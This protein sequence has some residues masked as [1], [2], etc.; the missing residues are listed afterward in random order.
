M[1][2]VIN[3]DEAKLIK[4]YEK[5]KHILINQE[6]I[7]LLNHVDKLKHLEILHLY[8]PT[9]LQIFAKNKN[10]HSLTLCNPNQNTIDTIRDLKGIQLLQ[11]Y[12]TNDNLEQRLDFSSC[13]DILNIENLGITSSSFIAPKEELRKKIKLSN[14]DK[15]LN[16]NLND[17]R[18]E[19]RFVEGLD[20]NDLTPNLEYISLEDY[21]DADVLLNDNIVQVNVDTKP[22]QSLKTYFNFNILKNLENLRYLNLSIQLL[23][24]NIN[25]HILKTCKNIELLHLNDYYRNQ[26]ISEN[27]YDL[28]FLKYLPNLI[29]IQYPNLS[30]QIILESKKYLIKNKIE[31]LAFDWVI[32][33]NF[34]IQNEFKN[35]YKISFDNPDPWILFENDELKKIIEDDIEINTDNFHFFFDTNLLKLSDNYKRDFPIIIQLNEFDTKKDTK[36]TLNACYYPDDYDEG[37]FVEDLSF[38]KNFQNLKELYI[39]DGEDVDNEFDLSALGFLKNLETVMIQMHNIKNIEVIFDLP[40][41]Y[42]LNLFNYNFENIANSKSNVKK[43]TTNGN[44]EKIIKY[45]ELFPLLEEIEIT[46][47]DSIEDSIFIFNKLPNIKKITLDEW[48]YFEEWANR[49]PWGDEPMTGV[50]DFKKLEEITYLFTDAYT[51]DDMKNL[52][53]VDNLCITHFG[54]GIYKGTNKLKIKNLELLSSTEHYFD[55]LN[56]ISNLNTDLESIEFIGADIQSN[57]NLNSFSKLN[58]LKKIV[59]SGMQFC[60]FNEGNWGKEDNCLEL[61]QLKHLEKLTYLEFSANINFYAANNEYL[62]DDN[63]MELFFITK[64]L[65]GLKSLATIYFAYVSFPN[66]TYFEN[67]Q[68]LQ[69]LKLLKSKFDLKINESSSLCSTLLKLIIEPSSLVDLKEINKFSKLTDLQISNYKDVID[70]EIF[71]DNKNLKTIRLK[72]CDSIKNLEKCKD[73]QFTVYTD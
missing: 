14:V 33:K 51:L 34:Y 50:L 39:Y 49:N 18:I 23:E 60:F 43:I 32:P 65:E 25:A 67:L 52:K 48:S 35:L 58:N 2:E 5:E 36:I 24:K 17:L 22:R 16:K 9:N 30:D 3:F 4:K 21:F 29:T 19:T 53:K 40:N 15:I 7:K 11:I 72:N 54:S 46:N 56:F 42:Y 61:D 27:S 55:S 45:Q 71:L 47:E 57:A 1:S 73:A 66:L 10:L 38:L 68:S 44:L 70:L 37:L 69:E 63:N 64:P 6:N 28:S 62:H 20:L 26:D 13:A 59:I 8:T 41:L 31:S 12:F